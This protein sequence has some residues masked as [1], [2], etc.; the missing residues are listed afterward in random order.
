MTGSFEHRAVGTGGSRLI[1]STCKT[2]HHP[3][4]ASKSK[5]TLKIAEDAHVCNNGSWGDEKKPPMREAA[6]AE[7]R[8]G[9]HSGS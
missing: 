2:C 1:K 5:A 7:R 6:P 4:A 3:I 9:I 8:P